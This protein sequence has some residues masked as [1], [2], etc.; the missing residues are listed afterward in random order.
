[1]V[2]NHYLCLIKLNWVKDMI[3]IHKI[4]IIIISNPDIDYLKESSLFD[5]FSYNPNVFIGLAI[6]STKL[7]DELNEILDYRIYSITEHISNL[8]SYEQVL[9][10]VLDYCGMSLSIDD[11][12]DIMFKDSTSLEQRVYLQSILYFKTNQDGKPSIKLPLKIKHFDDFINEFSE[13]INNHQIIDNNDDFS[14][15]N[16]IIDTYL[17]QE[18]AHSKFS[19]YLI[20]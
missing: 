18:E 5:F 20:K 4:K 10:D 3:N 6:D 12:L 13:D 9:I 19:N 11:T 1:M 14:E 8:E 7:R 16:V 2:I 17:T 15:S